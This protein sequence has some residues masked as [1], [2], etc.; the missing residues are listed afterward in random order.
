MLDEVG[1]DL[2]DLRLDRDHGAVPT[3]LVPGE[4]QRHVAEC[5]RAGRHAI[6]SFSTRSP[7]P[8]QDLA[9]ILPHLR[10]MDAMNAPPPST[11]VVV[12]GARCAGAATAMLLARQGHRVVLVDRATFPSDT[13]STHAVA[14][15]GVVQLARWGLLDAV[16]ASGA[17]AIRRV[18][19]HVGGEVIDRVI[20]ERAGVDLLVAPPPLRPR[21]SVGRGRQGGR[22]GGAHGRHRDRPH[23]GRR[24]GDRRAGSRRRGRSLRGR[25]A[26]RRR[27]RRPP[28]PCGPRRRRPARRPA[29]ARWGHALRLLRRAGVGRLRVPHR[30]PGDG[31]GVPDPRRRSQR[32]GVHAGGTGRRAAG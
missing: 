12:V 26:I 6:S 8:L 23:E 3:D 25:G 1:E 30:R 7:H 21:P 9:A 32:V 2:E 5:Q 18:R 29:P 4:V 24:P 11:D 22:G 15:G 20:K 14:R 13:I 16:L 19:F 28:L 10:A 27:R 31:R 17:P